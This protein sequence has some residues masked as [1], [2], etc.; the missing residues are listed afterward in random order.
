MAATLLVVAILGAVYL[1]LIAL[2]ATAIRH[3]AD[4]GRLDR[5]PRLAIWLAA[6]LRPDPRD[7]VPADPGLARDER[8]AVRRLMSG[9]LDKDTYRDTL[10]GIAAQ[11]AAAHPLQ[12]P[13]SRQ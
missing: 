4:G 5:R 2:H 1:A 6:H 13:Q 11:D 12:L 10:A 3:H 8:M 9:E 7:R